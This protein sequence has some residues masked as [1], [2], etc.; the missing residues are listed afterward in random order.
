[1]QTL[2]ETVEAGPLRIALERPREPA[3]LLRDDAYER[4][5]LMPYWAELWPAGVALARH[6]AKL[7][8]A[9]T[10]ALELGCGLGLPSLAAALSGA[11]VVATDWATDALE[12]LRANAVR[13]RVSLETLLL[14]WRKPESLHGRRFD[15]VLAAD[16]LYEEGNGRRLLDLLPR[17]LA[18]DGGV[19]VAD[20]GRRHAPELVDAA[21]TA[22]WALSTEPAQ[23]LPRGGIHRLHKHD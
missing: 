5:D 16:V 9:G 21:T 20:P 15:V 7:D 11:H 22:G 10:S 8:L 23:L 12:L 6:V 3:S 19:L 2:V 14:D 4:A 1:V 18:E 17:V 13:N